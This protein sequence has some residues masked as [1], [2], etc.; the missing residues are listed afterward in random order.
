MSYSKK[1]ILLL[2]FLFC[3][4]QYCQVF[5]NSF[6][7]I[8]KYWQGARFELSKDYPKSAPTDKDFPWLKYDFKK[9]PIDYL[10]AVLNYVYEGNIE[11]D[12][13]IQDNKIRKW[14]HAPSMSWPPFGREFIHGLTSER[15]SRPRELYPLQLDTF[16]NWAVGFYN[17][18]GG[19]TL[20][21]VWSDTINP[22]ISEGVFF[23][24]TVGAKLLFTEATI[25]Q[26]PYLNGSYEWDAYIFDKQQRKVI[27]KLRLLQL[28]IAVKDSRANTTTGWVFGTF[29]YNNN[30][31]GNSLW[32]KLVPVGIS[33]GNDPEIII[34]G[35]E[36]LETYINPEFM[37]LFTFPDGKVMHLGYKGRLNGPVDNPLSS[38]ISC[39]SQAQIPEVKKFLPNFKDNDDIR[40]YF[41]NISSGE[42][43]KPVAGGSKSMDYSLQLSRGVGYVL[44]HRNKVAT[45]NIIDSVSGLTTIQDN[46]IIDTTEIDEND[47]ELPNRFTWRHYLVLIFIGLL[48]IEVIIIYTKTNSHK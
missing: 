19:Y 21:K 35:G 34:S 31:I 45:E 12:W 38:C 40:Y 41:R 8:P 39:H 4:N 30:K 14:Y 33:W 27:K 3:D 28:D 13:K 17:P 22:L 5:V 48:I 44:T 16:Q 36:L 10:M 20:G 11:A 9:Q 43:F 42:V 24:G 26:V 2:I 29:V 18:Q 23:E 6:D 15:K 7:T 47:S 37:E 25:D 32:D 46:S 1:I